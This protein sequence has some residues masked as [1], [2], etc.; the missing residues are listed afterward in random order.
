MF[1]LHPIYILSYIPLFILYLIPFLPRNIIPHLLFTPLSFLYPFYPFRSP[2]VYFPSPSCISSFLSP[3]FLLKFMP[4]LTPFLTTTNFSYLVFQWTSVSLIVCFTRD[5][6]FLS[7]NSEITY[8]YLYT[9][10]NIWSQK[11]SNLLPW[12]ANWPKIDLKI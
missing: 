12:P 10:L 9:L 3:I 5:T 4:C 2:S 8:R 11:G 7:V 1:L 6:Y